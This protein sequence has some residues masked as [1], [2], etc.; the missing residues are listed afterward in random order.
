MGVNSY[1]LTPS[2]PGLPR[3]SA[4]KTA[5]NVGVTLG[6]GRSPGIGSGNPVQYFCLENPHGQRSLVGCSP[7]GRKE[8]DTTEH[9][10][11]HTP[12][13]KTLG[14]SQ[15]MTLDA[16]L[17]WEGHVSLLSSSPS[18]PWPQGFFFFFT[19]EILLLIIECFL[20][21]FLKKS[22]LSLRFLII[23]FFISW[24]LITL[25]YCSGFCHTLT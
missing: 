25:Q 23:F 12:G 9:T 1:H 6:S 7:W 13:P 16:D 24:R 15:A 4:R 20:S 10:R 3:G 18:L 5:C 14:S 21:W 22:N 17:H 11:I 2:A 8:P 19:E